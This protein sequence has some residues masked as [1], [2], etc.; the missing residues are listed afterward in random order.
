M[1]SDCHIAVES[2]GI[3]SE[4]PVVR[5]PIGATLEEPLSEVLRKQSIRH[6]IRAT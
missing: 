4:R 5:K 6:S 3:R 2:T 1:L